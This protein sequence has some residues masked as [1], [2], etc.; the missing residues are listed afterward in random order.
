MRYGKEEERRKERRGI[1]ETKECRGAG[2]CYDTVLRWVGHAGRKGK[3]TAKKDEIKGLI[4]KPQGAPTLAPES[5]KRPALN[6]SEKD[7]DSFE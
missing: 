1:N 2:Q 6:I 3:T 5:D 4:V 7:F